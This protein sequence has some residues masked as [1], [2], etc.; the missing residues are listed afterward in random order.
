MKKLQPSYNNDANKILKQVTQEKRAMEHLN[1][2]NDLAML[3]NDI[4]PTLKEPKTFNK[5]CNYPNKES[6]RKWQEVIYKEFTIMNKQQV[7]LRY[8]KVL[9]PSIAGA[10]K[11]NGSSKLSTMVYTRHIM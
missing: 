4:K 11:I 9:C 5:V 8:L 7:W 10:S 1:F 2:L 3:Y 6:L